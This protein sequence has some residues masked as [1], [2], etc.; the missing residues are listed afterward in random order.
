MVL[1]PATRANVIPLQDVHS[2]CC[3]AIRDCPPQN[4]A[5]FTDPL[6]TLGS[7]IFHLVISKLSISTLVAAE[8][9]SKA[10]W[11]AIRNNGAV[12]RQSAI[13]GGAETADILRL[14]ALPKCPRQWR[15]LCELY[16]SLTSGV[17]QL[18]AT[19]GWRAGMPKRISAY[20]LDPVLSVQPTRKAFVPLPAVNAVITLDSNGRTIAFDTGFRISAPLGMTYKAMVT[21]GDYFVGAD[22]GNTPRD[23]QETSKLMVLDIWRILPGRNEPGAGV[24]HLPGGVMKL[25]KAMS[26]SLWGFD[27][28]LHLGR[29]K[30]TPTLAIL[31]A[32]P[33]L[34][35]SDPATPHWVASRRRAIHI[36][37]LDSGTS[38]VIP[39]APKNGFSSVRSSLQTDADPRAQ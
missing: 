14:D 32:E 17:N 5:S 37:D 26:L 30:T 24:I 9:V 21:C 35:E 6:Q 39:L 1:S 12:W 8:Q 28:A 23:L 20:S 25:V 36:Y 3:F 18:P 29:G 27:I 4:R 34:F 11:L 15:D 38:Q 19:Q 2:S 33:R 31:G 7:D 22:W 13:H 10:W 16:I